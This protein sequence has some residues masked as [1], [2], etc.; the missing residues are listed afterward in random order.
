MRT[1]FKT[2]VALILVVFASEQ[3]AA[4]VVVRPPARQPTVRPVEMHPRSM[5]PSQ[6]SAASTMRTTDLLLERAKELSNGNLSDSLLHHDNHSWMVI[7]ADTVAHY[8]GKGTSREQ[9]QAALG[10]RAELASG[11]NSWGN[12]LRGVAAKGEAIQMVLER[13]TKNCVRILLAD[14]PGAYIHELARNT[15]VDMLRGENRARDLA[16]EAENTLATGAT[17]GALLGNPSADIADEIEALDIVRKLQVSLSE[18][19]VQVLMA[20]LE[21]KD[22]VDIARELKISADRVREIR[23]KIRA[24]FTK[25]TYAAEAS[26]N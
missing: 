14:N 20:L 6:G 13:I 3:I 17:F 25:L 4:Q 7:H 19:Q 8:C 5:T 23:E 26:A 22:T 11:V 2:I 12:K 10:L 1:T 24:Q 16:R 15:V 21:D 18:R 9:D